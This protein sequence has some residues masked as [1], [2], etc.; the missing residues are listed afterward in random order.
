MLRADTR[1]AFSILT[2]TALWARWAEQFPQEGVAVEAVARDDLEAVLAEAER[3]TA[4]DMLLIDVAGFYEE[5][6]ILAISAANMV[7]IPTQASAPDLMEAARIAE[8]IRAFQTRF[9][10]VVPHAL[11]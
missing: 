6:L 9:G 3:D 1:R 10:A 7:V 8:D 2:K 4:Y 11:L 5:S